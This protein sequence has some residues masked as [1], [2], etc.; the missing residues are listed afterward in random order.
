MVGMP[1]G[2]SP[3]PPGFGIISAQPLTG[4]AARRRRRPVGHV[5]VDAVIRAK[6][7][8]RVRFLVDSGA[9]QSL[10]PPELASRVGLEPSVVRETVRLAT[11]RTG[12]PP[13]A[14]CLRL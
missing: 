10:I 4:P 5:H 11:G 2:R 3:T 7:S 13:I 9:T 1:S 14:V 6:R 12:R 8:A